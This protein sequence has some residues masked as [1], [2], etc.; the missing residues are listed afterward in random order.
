MILISMSTAFGQ[1]NNFFEDGKTWIYRSY[2]PDEVAMGDYSSMSTTEQT[3]IGDT[4]V[5]GI[6]AKILKFV[7]NNNGVFSYSST[8]AYEDNGKVFS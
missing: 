7:T 3:V 5:Y 1:S 2:D 8:V 4:I 6:N